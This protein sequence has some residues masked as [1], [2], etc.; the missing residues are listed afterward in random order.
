MVIDEKLLQLENKFKTIIEIPTEEINHNYK[1]FAETLKGNLPE[2]RRETMKS[3]IDE[4]RNEQLIQDAERKERSPNL[5]IHGISEGCHLDE[6][7]Q[8]KSR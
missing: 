6:K 1:N 4:A 7:K 2:K 5:I 3:V 8:E